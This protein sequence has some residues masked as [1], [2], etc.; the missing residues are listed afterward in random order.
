LRKLSVGALSQQFPLRLIEQIISYSLS[1]AW[2]A[3][4]GGRD[5]QQKLADRLDH[6]PLTVLIDEQPQDLSLRSS[7]ACAKQSFS[8]G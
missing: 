3:P 6:K 2:K 1:R 4:I 8:E 5:D 7:S